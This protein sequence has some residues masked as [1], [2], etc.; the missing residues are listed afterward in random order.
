MLK[1]IFN[2]NFGNL[3]MLNFQDNCFGKFITTQQTSKVHANI[4][5]AHQSI[6]QSTNKHSFSRQ[7]ISCITHKTFILQTKENH[8][9]RVKLGVYKTKASS[10]ICQKCTIFHILCCFGG[11]M[12]AVCRLYNAELTAQ[13]MAATR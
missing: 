10:N 3:S 8:H 5:F 2:Y 11:L 4:H 9:G 6:L 1:L 13:N 7:S 12:S